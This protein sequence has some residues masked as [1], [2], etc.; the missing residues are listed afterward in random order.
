QNRRAARS[1]AH[2]CVAASELVIGPTTNRRS[3]PRDL[4]SRTA[5]IGCT[6]SS[7]SAVLLRSEIQRARSPSNVVAPPTSRP[8]ST[9]RDLAAS[10]STASGRFA[11]R[12]GAGAGDGLAVDGAAGADAEAA[13]APGGAAIGAAGGVG[14]AVAGVVFSGCTFSG[15]AGLLRGEGGAGA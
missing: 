15:C 4:F 3:T 2:I 10:P 14:A 11:T 5:T 6:S 13:M 7:S 1:V 8:K 12:V 9:I